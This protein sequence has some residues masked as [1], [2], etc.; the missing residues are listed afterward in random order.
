VMNTRSNSGRACLSPRSERR[1]SLLFIKLSIAASQE[2]KRRSS[3]MVAI[4]L[5]QY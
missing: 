3:R 1:P 5:C 2:P 4:R